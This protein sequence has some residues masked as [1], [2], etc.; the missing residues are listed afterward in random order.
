M[1]KAL[2]KLALKLGIAKKKIT[3]LET[4]IAYLESLIEYYDA[5]PRRWTY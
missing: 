3:K 5:E 4:R 2:H 1:N